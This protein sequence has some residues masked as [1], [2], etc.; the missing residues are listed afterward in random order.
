MIGNS[1][2]GNKYTVAVHAGEPLMRLPSRVDPRQDE[3]RAGSD[4]VLST[5]FCKVATTEVAGLA[6]MYLGMGWDTVP[7]SNSCTELISK[8]G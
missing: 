4:Q 1:L 7:Q 6:H 5:Y 2:T 8:D 3:I